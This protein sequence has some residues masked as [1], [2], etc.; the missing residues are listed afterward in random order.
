MVFVPAEAGF[1]DL[2]AEA[3]GEA[4]AAPLL[5]QRI[6]D[7][8]GHGID[9][10]AE[11]PAVELVAGSRSDAEAEA[12]APLVLATSATE[13]AADPEALL[14]ECF[15]PVTLLIRYGSKGDLE[16]GLAAVKAA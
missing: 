2:V 7:G 9:Q 1:E 6:V 12:P 3:M 14:A 11:H 13:V 4:K 16:S 15:G 8:F 5:N 10:L